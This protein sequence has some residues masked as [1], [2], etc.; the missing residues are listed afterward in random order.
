MFRRLALLLSLLGLLGLTAVVTAMDE[1]PQEAAKAMKDA[2]E[3]AKAIFAGGCFW[4]MEPP[5]E[6]LD[7]VISVTSGFTGGHVPNPSYDQ[8]SA[9]GTG[10]A[11]AVEILYDPKKISY[12]QLLDVFWRQINPTD[13]GGQ[14]VDRGNQYRSGIFT[15]NAEQQRL[16][17]ESK[18]KLGASGRFDRPIVTAI[19][20]ATAFYPAE[21]YHQDY[22]KKNPLRY[23]FYRYRSGRDDF[24]EKVWGEKH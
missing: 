10:H 6:K 14:F 2:P 20:P 19:V 8:V 11:E 1:N 21:E 22:Y 3:T 4:C 5:F 23:K 24:L 13:A 15:L 7:G 16:A 9:G 12:Q 17:K 18:Q